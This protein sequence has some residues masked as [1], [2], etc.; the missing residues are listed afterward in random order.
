M[1][2]VDSI[3]ARLLALH[4]KRIDL[5]LD[6][7]TRVL[8]R[9]G[10]P[11]QH[12]PPV[13][14]VA[15]TNGKG[16]TIAFLRAMLEA[17]GKSV[18]VYTSPNL[19]RIN[20]RFRLGRPDGGVLVTD[21]ELADAL[22]ECERANGDAPITI[23]EIETAA[24]FTLF[25]RNP[26]DILLLEVGLGGR[27][28]ATNVIE[29]PLVSVIT[30]ISMDHVEFLG[31]TI[32][33]IAAEKA[34][35]LRRDVPAVIAPQADAALTVI[36]RQAARVRAPL[37]AAGQHWTTS[38][39]HSRLVY[40]DEQGLFDLPPPKLFGR[41]QFDNAGTAIAALRAAGIRVPIKAVEQGLT[42]AE[43]PA[44]LQ[45]LT[46]GR[47]VSLA[48]A[49][50]ELWL[51]GGH[52]AEGGR[53]IAAALAD[54]EDR[55]SRPLLLVVGMLST[56]DRD[57]FLRNFTGLVRRVYGVPIHQEKGV[58]AEEIAASAQAA[59]MPADAAPDLESALAAIGALGF[60][61]PPRILI[62]GSLY[63][64]GEVLAL[65]GTEPT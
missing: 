23:F 33:K 42:R 45:R 16:S 18:H 58:P 4:P 22:A 31:D 26:A 46:S 59:G 37:Y 48:P 17:A 47:L 62:T 65:N 20:E 21:G 8:K 40:Q 50:A 15:G 29:H 64:A 39:E 13:I 30:P 34:G 55:V 60:D 49:G 24:A 32:E 36:E 2:P 41:H 9:L 27:L 44:R 51:D 38:V 61:P 25:A 19:V 14:H 1:T 10:H 28:D 56:K 57:G 63:L 7:M 53:A 43:W 5:S 3:L 54:L 11:E 6:R 12:V 35:I 52:N